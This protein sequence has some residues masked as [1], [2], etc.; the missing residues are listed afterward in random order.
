MSNYDIT[1]KD[2]LQKEGG[3]FLTE[4]ARQA[5]K[6][7]LSGLNEKKVPPGVFMSNDQRIWVAYLTGAGMDYNKALEAIAYLFEVYDEEALPKVSLKDN[8]REC[9]E[10]EELVRQYIASLEDGTYY[11]DSDTEHYIQEAAIKACCGEHIFDW[12]KVRT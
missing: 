7:I 1:F 3:R 2:W 4:P 10:L 6:I 12:I 8:P 9:A 11:C 5:I